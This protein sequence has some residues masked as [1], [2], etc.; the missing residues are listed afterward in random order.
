MPASQRAWKTFGGS[1]A[2]AANKAGETTRA[3]IL[4]AGLDIMRADPTA[5]NSHSIGRAL[6]RPHQT[7]LYHFKTAE[8]LRDAVAAHAVKCDDRRVIRYLI[9]TEHVAVAGMR[10]AAGYLG[11]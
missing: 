1:L 9:V 7:V 5:L 3:A 4:T 11:G 8:A 10:D 6:H 2:V